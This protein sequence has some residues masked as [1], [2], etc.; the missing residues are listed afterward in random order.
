M[1]EKIERK[2]LHLACRHHILK[3]ILAN[4]FSLH[5]VSNLQALKSLPVSKNTSLILII[6]IRQYIAQLWKKVWLLSWQPGR[7]VSLHLQSLNR[8]N[9][10]LEMTTESY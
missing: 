10:N 2:L 9:F 7:T 3:L 1:E 8:G 6:L 4:V 5:D